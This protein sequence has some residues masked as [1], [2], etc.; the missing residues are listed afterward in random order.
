L[1]EYKS[2]YY[3]SSDG[4][5]LFARDYEHIAPKATLLC[6]HGILGNSR[7]FDGLAS[8]L[9]TDYRLIVPDSRGRG[10]SEYS[11]TAEGF[12]QAYDIQDVHQLI[13]SLDVDRLF[14][15]GTSMGGLTGMIMAAISTGHYLGEAIEALRATLPPARSDLVRGLVMNDVGP[16]FGPRAMPTA[17]ELARS[18]RPVNSWDDAARLLRDASADSF[19][20]YTD[21]DWHR[22]AA[23]LYQETEQ[24]VLVRWCHPALLPSPTDAGSSPPAPP[25]PMWPLFDAIAEIP[26]LVLRGELSGTLTAECVQEMQRRKTNLHTAVI[27]RRGHCPTLREPESRDAIDGFLANFH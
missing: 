1:A 21:A 15:I 13:A 8:H 5:R 14:V 18:T 9:A 6:L 20:D 24:G 17:E 25:P 22:A 4:L 2:H 23:E 3:E 27:P 7:N 19:P 11:T 16:E 12:L 10:L 26:T